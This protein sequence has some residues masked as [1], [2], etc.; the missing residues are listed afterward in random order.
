M[1]LMILDGNSIVNRAFYG[2]RPLTTKDGMFT[3][4]IYGF[5]NILEKLRTDVQP[6]ALCVAFDLKAPTF[7]HLRYDQYKAKRHGMPDELAMQM[8]VLKEVLTA[9]NIPIYEC[10][11]WE[12]DDIIG[13]VGKR[14]GSS[15]WD[16]VIVTGDR[17][18]LQLVDDH[19]TVK[20]VTS[21]AG[22]TLTTNY[23]PEKFQEDY[24]F[25]PVKLIDLKSLMG[26]SS[27]NIPG[28]AGIGPKTA[29]ELL[30]QFSSLDGIYEHLQAPELK[31][32][33]R[34][35]LE[36][37][38]EMAYLSYDLASIRCNAPI[39]F[40]PEQNLVQ[41]PNKAEL[42]ALFT[43]LEFVKLMDRY[44]LF[45]LEPAPVEA[46]KPLKELDS[47]PPLHM[48]CAICVDQEAA[49]LAV[50][51]DQGVCQASV[52]EN[53]DYLASFLASS[54]PKACA[55]YKNLRSCFIKSGL[56]CEEFDFDVTLAAYVLNP[57]ETDFQLNRVASAY[58]GVEP[59]DLSGQAASVYQLWQTLKT[60]I[61]QEGLERVYYDIELPLCRVLS[62]MELEGIAVDQM[63][64]I[65]FGNMLSQR[66]EAAQQTIFTYAGEEFN[67][68]STK[69]LGEILF[70][71]LSL[72]PV[73]KTKSGY[74]TDVEV[75]EKLRA[76]H[77][78]V[79][80]VMDYR[81]LTKLKSTYADGLLKVI[82]ED[83]RIHT[84]F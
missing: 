51:T 44:H 26:D 23:T 71:K 57:S 68:N 61:K 39:A 2:V 7:R 25:E 11:G 63:T 66:I 27:D 28:V 48:P 54:T 69:K 75:L 81:M 22:Q 8:P 19:V 14:C 82:A 65:A 35:K 62:N 33:V 20:L 10:E 60:Q 79:E 70:E 77:P 64:L 9:M 52:A 72:P 3:N 67:I 1:K 6:E 47:L 38:K 13:T 76:K 80:A 30:L 53:R 58:L 59:Q 36:A 40:S 46:A 18:S 12:A 5:L 56:P 42:K 74:S 84:T 45:E 32:S 55:D 15:G 78:I 34:K 73:K 4:A 43:K 83:G 24:G 49:C 37:G 50:A 41:A 29:T 31:E 16:C 21:K 17:D